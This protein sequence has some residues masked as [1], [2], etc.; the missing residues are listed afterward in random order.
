MGVHKQNEANNPTSTLILGVITGNGD[1]TVGRISQNTRPGFGSLIE[2]NWD[3]ICFVNGS[4][5]N[6]I[7]K[8]KFG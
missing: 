7:G 1:W 2:A 3:R 8:Q 4:A 5:V 6:P